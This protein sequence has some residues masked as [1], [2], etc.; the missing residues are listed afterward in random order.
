[1]PNKDPD[2]GKGAVEGNS[3]SDNNQVS[4]K[5]QLRHRHGE[6]LDGADSDLPEPGAREEHS[7]EPQGEKP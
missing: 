6:D 4:L 3:P 1:M 5:G 2:A 7:G